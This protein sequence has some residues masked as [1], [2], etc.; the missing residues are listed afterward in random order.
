MKFCDTI[1]GV[2]IILYVITCNILSPTR[3]DFTVKYIVL[4]SLLFVYHFVKVKF[5]KTKIYKEV[6]KYVNILAVIAFAGF[7]IMEAIIIA[8]PKHNKDK[9]DYIVVLGAGLSNGTNVSLTLKGRLDKAIEA[10]K[11]SNE[12]SMIVVSGGQGGDEDITE[13]E[14]MEKYLVENGIEKS[15]IIKE[16]K[17]RNT[18][19]NFKFS[20]VKIEEDSNKDIKDVSVKIVTTDFHSFRSAMLAKR[21]GYE[22][23][24][25]DASDTVNYLVPRLYVR[26][27]F[28][29]V[30]SFVFDRN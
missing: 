16:D 24:T 18:Y 23:I 13:A 8:Y 20:K 19:Q 1:V 22:N 11:E 25:V 2:I 30:K 15:K 3:L 5:E 28:A 17:S 6:I 21:N 29:I 10:F 7:I 27:A 14:A 9:N 4:A 12:E 26:E